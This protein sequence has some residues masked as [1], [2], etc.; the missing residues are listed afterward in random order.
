[1]RLGKF[2]HARSAECFQRVSSP[3]GIKNI[4]Y[5]PYWIN[6]APLASKADNGVP[7]SSLKPR[8]DRK[9]MTRKRTPDCIS[10]YKIM[11]KC[12]NERDGSLRYTS[13]IPCRPTIMELTRSGYDA[14]HALATIERSSTTIIAKPRCLND[15]QNR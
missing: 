4:E 3:V 5:R 1:M 11:D 2:C 6:M 12:R 8:N 10:G 14:I 9:S 13:H 7:C 15:V